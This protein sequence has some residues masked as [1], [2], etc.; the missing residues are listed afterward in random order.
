MNAGSYE[1]QFS[2]IDRMLKRHPT[3]KFWLR[4]KAE[5]TE[6]YDAWKAKQ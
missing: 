2:H 5:W 6:R 4:E 1:R 3:D